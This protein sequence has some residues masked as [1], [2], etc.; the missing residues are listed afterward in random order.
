MSKGIQTQPVFGRTK[1]IHMV[2]IG[3][4]GMSGIAEILLIRG[5]TVTGSD[6]SVSETTERLKKLGATIFPGHSASNIDGADVVVYT[7]AVKAKENVETREAIARQIPV[8]KRSEMLAE[9]MRMKYGIG[10]AGTHGKTT[11]TTMTGH[12]VQDGKFDPTI[13]VGGRVHSFDKTNAVVGKGDI[14]L[15]EADEYD[16]TFL[17]LSPSMAVIT[18][19]EAEHLDIY[20]D[21]DDVKSAFIEFANKVPFYGVVIVCL[22]DTNVRSILPDIDRRTI[23]YGFTPQAQVRAINVTQNGFKSTFNVMFE[24]KI[25]G[26]VTINSP[27]EHNI[28]NALASVAVGLELGMKFKQIK[29]GLERFEGVFRRFQPKLEQ[30][31]LI[32]IDDYAHHP[33]EVQASIEG[34]RRGWKDRRIVAVFQP[35]LYSR[36]QQMYGEFGLSFFDAEVL[37]VTDVY[38]SREKPIEGVTGKLISDTAKQYGHRNV[39]YMKDKTALPGKLKEIVKDGDIVITMGAGDIYRYGEQFVDMIKKK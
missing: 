17:R 31:N 4:I 12:V 5:Y 38:P 19:I 26:E 34:A 29:S 9:L 23:S 27:G 1:H 39:H 2:G 10:I 30:D 13:I 32:V 14:L 7:S 15:V 21:L 3:G 28:S 8:I 6:S 24:D 18:N 33:T 11:T 16:R 25:L 35:H 20:E 37:V 36:T 22:D